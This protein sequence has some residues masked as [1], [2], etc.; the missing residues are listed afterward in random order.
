M[1]RAAEEQ[2]IVFCLPP[3]TTHLLQPLDK[4]AFGPLKTY[5]NEECQYYMSKNPGKV[6]TEYE[7]M[8][9]FSK[10]WYRAMTIPNMMA[11]FRITGVYPFSRDAVVSIAT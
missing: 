7:F 4:G 11:A 5:W 10:S 6:L 2:V 9:V 1:R 8:P 3:N